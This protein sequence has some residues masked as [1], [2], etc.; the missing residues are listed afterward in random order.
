MPIARAGELVPRER[1]EV[2]HQPR[3][4]REPVLARDRE[5]RVG[6]L[7]LVRLRIRA[8]LQLR[9]NAREGF[10]IALRRSS[11]R[12]FFACLRS[13]SRFGRAGSART[14]DGESGACPS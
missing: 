9:A 13:N 3:P 4:A 2:L 7:E 14:S 8:A 1:L 6:Q 11:A 12:S 10:G 5:L